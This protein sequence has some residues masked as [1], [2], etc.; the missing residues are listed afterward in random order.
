LL[1]AD[2][3]ADFAAG[4]VALLR[5]PERRV[6]LGRVAR[7]FVEQQYDWR[8]IVPRV[9]VAYRTKQPPVSTGG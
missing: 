9:E 4:V 5:T 7:A 6:E 8:V 3:P 1:L 2:T